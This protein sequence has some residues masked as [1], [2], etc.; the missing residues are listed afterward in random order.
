MLPQIQCIQSLSSNAAPIRAETAS[1]ASSGLLGSV[2]QCAMVLTEVGKNFVRERR[3]Q[4][5]PSRRCI[6]DVLAPCCPCEAQED[7]L[8]MHRLAYEN[9]LETCSKCLKPEDVPQRTDVCYNHI[10]S[11]RESYCGKPMP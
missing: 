8:D 10:V 9:E 5:D 3:Q 11:P 4:L 1:L 6:S 7:L 2:K